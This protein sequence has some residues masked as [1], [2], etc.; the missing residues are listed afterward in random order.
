[1]KGCSY[2]FLQ[3][4][5]CWRDDSIALAQHQPHLGHTPR[6]CDDLDIFASAEGVQSRPLSRGPWFTAEGMNAACEC[7]SIFSQAFLLSRVVA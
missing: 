4:L 7:L 5:F 3:A 1:M 6:L 2:V